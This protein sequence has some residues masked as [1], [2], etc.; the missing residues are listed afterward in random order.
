[1]MTEI[2][3][4]VL[5]AA[6]ITTIITA[7]VA[8]LFGCTWGTFLLFSI[9]FIGWAFGL[10]LFVIVGEWTYSVWKKRKEKRKG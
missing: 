4:K 6:I 5:L 7:I 1:M 9:S 3:W 8:K 10:I 2:W